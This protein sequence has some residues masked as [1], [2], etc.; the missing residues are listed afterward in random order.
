MKE[1]VE[2]SLDSTGSTC[3]RMQRSHTTTCEDACCDDLMKMMINNKL[4]W[5]QL[6]AG[7]VCFLPLSVVQTSPA[8][9]CGQ[10]NSSLIIIFIRSSHVSSQVLVWLFCI[11]SSCTYFLLSQVTFR[12]LPSL[13]NELRMSILESSISWKL[14]VESFVSCCLYFCA[15]LCCTSRSLIVFTF[16]TQWKLTHYRST[17]GYRKANIRAFSRPTW[18]PFTFIDRPAGN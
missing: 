12:S 14:C 3:R 17:T 4:G 7:L 18:R 9:S 1:V 2:M 15:N 10:P 16:S 8:I 5:P 13:Q 11:L 6:T